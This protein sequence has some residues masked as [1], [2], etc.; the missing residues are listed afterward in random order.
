M[1]LA[2]SDRLTPSLSAH[3][4]SGWNLR[5]YSYTHLRNRFPAQRQIAPQ[6][7]SL[8]PF[9]A[10]KDDSVGIGDTG[11]LVSLRSHPKRRLRRINYINAILEETSQG[12]WLCIYYVHRGCHGSLALS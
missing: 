9:G 8:L 5:N 11:M 4:R 7:G 3:P 2:G 12:A 1:K 6:D 10:M